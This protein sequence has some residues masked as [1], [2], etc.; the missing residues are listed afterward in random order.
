M[1][2][3]LVNVTLPQNCQKNGRISQNL[4]AFLIVKI[5]TAHYTP[6]PINVL[7]LQQKSHPLYCMPRSLNKHAIHH[8][9]YSRDFHVISCHYRLGPQGFSDH[10]H[11]IVCYHLLNKFFPFDFQK[12]ITLHLAGLNSICQHVAQQSN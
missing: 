5:R 8:L 4:G 9:N 11:P 3:K 12:C 7:S 2:R 6:S 1:I 10:Q